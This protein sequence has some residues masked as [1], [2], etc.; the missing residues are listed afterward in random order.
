MKD[1]IKKHWSNILFVGFILAFFFVPGV[2]EFIQKPFL[3]SPSL[4]KIEVQGQLSDVDYNIPLKGINV[5]DANL[6]D[7]KG[8]NLFLNFWGSWCPPCRT[9]FPTI[10]KLYEQ[11]GDKMAFVLIA[12]QD[13]EQKVR[14]FL[15]KHHYTTP[16]YIVNEPLPKKLEFSF[17][18]TSFIINKKGEI[19]KKDESASNWN[20]DAVHQFIDGLE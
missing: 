19:L 18:P 3:M 15:E 8:E 13:E 9:E 16:V 4:G 17:F 10:Q 2:R 1:W 11:K 12:M 20:S 7:F 14:D 5:P 6:A